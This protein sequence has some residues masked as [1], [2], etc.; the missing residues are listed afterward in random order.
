M[1]LSDELIGRELQLQTD[2]RSK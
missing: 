2:F 1:S